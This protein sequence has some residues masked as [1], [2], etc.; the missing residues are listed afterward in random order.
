MSLL[1]AVE[2]L[3][4]V[5]AVTRKVTDATARVARPRVAEA[6]LLETALGCARKI[7]LSAG[8]VLRF[9]PVRRPRLTA[10]DGTALRAHARDVARLATVVADTVA[11]TGGEAAR[12]E[13]GAGLRVLRALA[14]LQCGEKAPSQS[15]PDPSCGATEGEA[16]ARCGRRH[17]TCSRSWGRPRSGSRLRG[18]VADQTEFRLKCKFRLAYGRCGPPGCTVSES[19]GDPKVSLGGAGNSAT[20][21]DNFRCSTGGCRRSGYTEERGI[22]TGISLFGPTFSTSP[23]LEERRDFPSRSDVT[24][25]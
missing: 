15:R 8:S 23:H 17:R 14:R 21:T 18:R 7:A 16:D 9:E 19:E 1:T 24:G 5:D 2:A 13:A 3:C 20:G 6:A 11:A 12:G 25:L 4:R 22:G 10:T